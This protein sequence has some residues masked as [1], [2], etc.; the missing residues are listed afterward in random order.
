[1]TSVVMTSVCGDINCD[2]VSMMT[3]VAMVVL[4]WRR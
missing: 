2:D 1:M 4:Q 3:V